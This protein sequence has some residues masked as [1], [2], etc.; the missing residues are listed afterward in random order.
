[1]AVLFY[2]L[3]LRSPGQSGLASLG[4]CL[5]ARSKSLQACVCV[6]P[7]PRIVI[8]LSRVSATH[9]IPLN[10]IVTARMGGV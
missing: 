2:E 10:M 3:S 4:N 9:S 7:N 6:S 5:Q 8:P 1:M